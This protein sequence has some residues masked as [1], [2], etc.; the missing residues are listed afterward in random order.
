[1]ESEEAAKKTLEKLREVT[2][3]GKMVKARLKSESVMKTFFPPASISGG[4]GGGDG[5]PGGMASSIPPTVGGPF[6]AGS[7][8]E[9]TSPRAGGGGGFYP[10]ATGGSGSSSAPAS[11]G[12]SPFGMS[13]GGVHNMGGPPGGRT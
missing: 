3:E 1:M 12:P 13:A 6:A 11:R 7:V 5:T 9:G 10:G 2:F 8:G 4:A